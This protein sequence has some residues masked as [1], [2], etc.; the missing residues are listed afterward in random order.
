MFVLDSA[1]SATIQ[2]KGC[3][4]THV[5]CVY[6]CV[7]VLGLAEGCVWVPAI[8]FGVVSVNVITH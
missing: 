7:C 4:H 1:A 3:I 5:C 8:C 6:V 2:H